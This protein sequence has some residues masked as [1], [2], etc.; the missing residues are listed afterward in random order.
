LG[1]EP[2]INSNVSDVRSAEATRGGGEVVAPSSL[3]ETDGEFPD[4]R[5]DDLSRSRPSYD[6]GATHDQDR[7]LVAV[8]DGS[9]A[10]PCVAL[11]GHRE[12]S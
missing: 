7:A 10:P 6:E 12:D 4:D 11:A 2:A 1:Y 8:V 9:A 3:N 5:V